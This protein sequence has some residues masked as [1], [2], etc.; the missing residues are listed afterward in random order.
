MTVPT[1]TPTLAQETIIAVPGIPL[2]VWWVG[3]LF[4]I[5]VVI[6]VLFYFYRR[7]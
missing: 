7:G 1:P 3:A 5:A 4:V 6:T 2:W